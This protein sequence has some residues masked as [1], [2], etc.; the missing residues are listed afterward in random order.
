M[1][2]NVPVSVR[3]VRAPCAMCARKKAQ[4]RGVQQYNNNIILT[5]VRGCKTYII[6]VTTACCLRGVYETG[7]ARNYLGSELTSRS[8]YTHTNSLAYTPLTRIQYLHNII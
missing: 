4:K 2:N 8:V 3:D 1:T 7:H 6:F 5:C